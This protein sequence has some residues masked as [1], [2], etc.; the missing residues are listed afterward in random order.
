MPW[1]MDLVGAV[2]PLLLTGAV[3]VWRRNDT[4][5]AGAL[6]QLAA[7][8]AKEIDTRFEAVER[9]T[10]EHHADCVQRFDRAEK[11]SSKLTGMVQ[12][13]T[14]LRP[15]VEALERRR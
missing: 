10:E 11:E 9:R 15:R 3:A 5:L 8:R 13:L 4:A 12:A 14:D 7:A 2:A 1:W 6:Q